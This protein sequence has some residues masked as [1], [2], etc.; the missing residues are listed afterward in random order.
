[1]RKAG[2]ILADC[3]KEIKKLIKPG[4]TTEEIDAFAENFILQEEPLQNKGLSRLSFC[5]LCIY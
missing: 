1:M 4:I 5:N 3:H 2:E